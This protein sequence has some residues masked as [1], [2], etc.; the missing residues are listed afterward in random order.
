MIIKITVVISDVAATKAKSFILCNDIGK[1]IERNIKIVNN[2]FIFQRYEESIILREKLHNF[3]HFV[4]RNQK[5]NA[6]FKLTEIRRG[7]KMRRKKNSNFRKKKKIGRIEERER[8]KRSEI[9]ETAEK[10]DDSGGR[11]A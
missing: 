8:G 5:R 4:L 3:L 2:N 9:G 10:R 6:R 11:V 1:K 7:L